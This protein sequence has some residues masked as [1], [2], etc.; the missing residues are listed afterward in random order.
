MTGSAGIAQRS[1]KPPRVRVNLDW[2]ERAT[3][4]QAHNPDIFFTPDRY[5]EAL[6]YCAQCPVLTECR[7]YG[8]GMGEGVWGGRIQKGEPPTADF[9]HGTEAGYKSHFRR[10]EI[11]CTACKESAARARRANANRRTR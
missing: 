9:Q 2:Q 1:H 7:I 4:T 6:E 3:C 8:S 10:S 11:P 5:E